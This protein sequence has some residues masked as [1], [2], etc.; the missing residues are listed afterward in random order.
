MMT[1]STIQMMKRKLHLITC[2]SQAKTELLHKENMQT[3]MTDYNM[4]LTKIQTLNQTC[5]KTLGTPWI[6]SPLIN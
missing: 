1:V 5:L 2:D 6:T 4:K 3:V